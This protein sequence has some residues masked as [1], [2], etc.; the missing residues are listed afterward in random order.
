VKENVYQPI[1]GGYT[2]GAK[3]IAEEL[4]AAYTGQ[5]TPKDALVDA[6]RRATLLLK[7]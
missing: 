4:V 6:E 2:D 5:K 3:A 1:Y 7:P